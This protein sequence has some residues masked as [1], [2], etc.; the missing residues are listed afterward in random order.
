ME[1]RETKSSILFLGERLHG[2][3][4]RFGTAV[5]VKIC[6]REQIDE[7]SPMGGSALLGDPTSFR[8]FSEPALPSSIKRGQVHLAKA[9]GR[10]REKKFA[11]PDIGNVK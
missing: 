7:A 2:K 3:L 1:F 5:R 10:D 9:D 11:F 8:A 4:R 6:K